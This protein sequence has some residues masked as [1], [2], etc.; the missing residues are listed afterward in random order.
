M[1]AITDIT[2]ANDNDPI[3]LTEACKMFPLAK[4]TPSTLRAEANRGTLTI[5]RLGKRDYTTVADMRAMVRQCHARARARTVDPQAQ[6]P[7]Q[8]LVE[9]SESD[10]VAAVRAALASKLAH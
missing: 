4:L 5:F 8:T 3:P 7:A 10:R 1:P 2:A 9:L 6:T